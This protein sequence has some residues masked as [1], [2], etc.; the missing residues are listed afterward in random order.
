[1]PNELVKRILQT[2]PVNSTSLTIN[3]KWAH[4]QIQLSPP[5]VIVFPHQA[6]YQVFSFYTR[7]QNLFSL[8]PVRCR[9]PMQDYIHKKDDA[10]TRSDSFDD[11]R[12][13]ETSQALK[14]PLFSLIQT[15]SNWWGIGAGLRTSWTSSFVFVLVFMSNSYG[16]PAVRKFCTGSTEADSRRMQLPT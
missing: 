8:P 3:A 1:M 7:L 13:M 5:D 10:K 16:L 6:K 2:L 9:I 11:C 15:I 4:V 12:R 14:W